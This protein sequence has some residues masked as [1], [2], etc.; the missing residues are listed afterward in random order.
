MRRT[1]SVGKPQWFDLIVCT[2]DRQRG[3]G[4]K[5][6]DLRKVILLPMKWQNE[7]FVKVQ[8]LGTKDV[9]RLHLDLILYFNNLEVV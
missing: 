4:G 7:R 8:P 9:I 2:A 3:T 1:N 6:L 5:I